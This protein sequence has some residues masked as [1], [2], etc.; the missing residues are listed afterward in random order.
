[1]LLAAVQEKSQ[2]A[3]VLQVVMGQRAALWP[4]AQPL[5]M[6]AL[7]GWETPVEATAETTSPTLTAEEAETR[8]EVEGCACVLATLRPGLRLGGVPLGVDAYMKGSMLQKALEI[9]SYI[10]KTVNSL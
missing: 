4:Q 5:G 6:G 10:D 1:M 9:V 2:S 3:S 8:A 7:M